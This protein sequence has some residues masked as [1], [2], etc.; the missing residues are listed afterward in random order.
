MISGQNK[1]ENIY[2]KSYFLIIQRQNYTRK[3]LHQNEQVTLL[4]VRLG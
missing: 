4:Q 2:G 3:K 1:T